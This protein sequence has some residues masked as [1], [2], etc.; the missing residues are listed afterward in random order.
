MSKRINS[1]EVIVLSMLG[2]SVSNGNTVPE[3]TQHLGP[4]MTKYA[5]TEGLISLEITAVYRIRIFTDIQGAFPAG[6]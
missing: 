2:L 5:I 3:G 4:E 1:R 6:A